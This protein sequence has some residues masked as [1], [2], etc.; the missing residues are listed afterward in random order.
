MA[1]SLKFPVGPNAGPGIFGTQGF[2]GYE[3][4]SRRGGRDGKA[5]ALK[6]GRSYIHAHSPP[7]KRG[8]GQS[9]QG[10]A[11]N[12][13]RFRHFLRLNHRN[14]FTASVLCMAQGTSK[15]ILTGM[16]QPGTGHWRAARKRQGALCGCHVTAYHH[17]SDSWRAFTPL[18]SHGRGA[19]TG[20][21]PA[22]PLDGGNRSSAESEGTAGGGS[23]P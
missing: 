21:C 10:H 2:S 18:T 15:T 14:K 4:V 13:R 16:H 19:R 11:R 7:V 12:N 8:L 23:M 9:F 6:Y 17:D 20:A 3:A 22:E 5:L 1:D